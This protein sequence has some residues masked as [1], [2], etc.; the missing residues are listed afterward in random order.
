[1]I[2]IQEQQIKQL[3]YIIKPYIQAAPSFLFKN[4]HYLGKT[5]I[6]KHAHYM[7]LASMLASVP[8]LHNILFLSKLF[9]GFPSAFRK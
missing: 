5:L 4:Y 8:A 2:I 9:K 6:N 7:S 1:M 3:I